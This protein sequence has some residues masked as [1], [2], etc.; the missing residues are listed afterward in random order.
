M[1]KFSFK[2]VFAEPQLIPT[3]S[4]IS[5]MVKQR[6]SMINVNDISISAQRWPLSAD[7]WPSLKQLNHSLVSAW[8]SPSF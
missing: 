8:V 7:M 5:R 6:F 1:P 3:S 4:A 2:I